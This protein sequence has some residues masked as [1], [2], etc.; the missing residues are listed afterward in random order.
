MSSIDWP[1]LIRVGLHQLGLEPG[2]FW[3]LTPVELRI[4][5]GA[6]V[7]HPPLTRARLA[8]LAAAFPDTAKDMEHGADRRT[9]GAGGGA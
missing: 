1:G 4:M 6:D 3:C 2:V 7:A 8:E 9:A 5:L